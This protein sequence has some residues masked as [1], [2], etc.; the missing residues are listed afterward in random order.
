MKSC[1]TSSKITQL[2]IKMSFFN[3]NNGEVL[4]DESGVDQGMEKRTLLRLLE[5]LRP[6]RNGLCGGWFSSG[7]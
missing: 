1:S 2:T 6:L 7:I 4:Q 3:I 5:T